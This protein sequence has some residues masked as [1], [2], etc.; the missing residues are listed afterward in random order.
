MSL[1]NCRPR[2]KYFNPY[3]QLNGMLQLVVPC[4]IALH[5][6]HISRQRLQLID[7]HQLARHHA[8]RWLMP[9]CQLRLIAR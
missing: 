9:V 1:A 8:L 6:G 7:L 5:V 2:P 3:R 4:Q